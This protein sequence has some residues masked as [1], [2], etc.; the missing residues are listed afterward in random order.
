MARLEV[1]ARRFRNALE[2]FR[3]WPTC[4]EGPSMKIM[5]DEAISLIV[6]EFGASWPAWLADRQRDTPN[7]VIEAQAASE[8]AT[9]F[10]VRVI[11]RVEA[12]GSRR[13]FARLAV[14]ATNGETDEESIAARYRIARA[15]L[16]TMANLDAAGAGTDAAG[17]LVLAADA[18]DEARHGLFALAGTLCDELRGNTNLG[19]SVRFSQDDLSSR[20]VRSV[21]PSAPDFEDARRERADSQSGMSAETA[22]FA[23]VQARARK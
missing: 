5:Q 2:R 4:G 20:T 19:V 21:R 9:E 15:M 22:S 10:A 14:I 17:E 1:A 7:A 3:V 8:S 23:P 16:H 11:R 13:R 12:L 6:L 18:G